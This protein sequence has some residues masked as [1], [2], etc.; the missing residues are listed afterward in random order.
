MEGRGKE[1]KRESNY[2]KCGRER[3][4]IKVQ[5]GEG[6]RGGGREGGGRKEERE[7]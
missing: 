5:E 3:K 6:V 7:G 1:R 4:Y 2:I